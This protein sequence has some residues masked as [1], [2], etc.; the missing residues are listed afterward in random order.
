M[1]VAPDYCVLVV[2]FSCPSVYILRAG[3]LPELFVISTEINLLCFVGVVQNNKL[4]LQLVEEQMDGPTITV[5]RYVLT[6]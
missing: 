3:P 5:Y 2:F 6:H 4:R 1:G